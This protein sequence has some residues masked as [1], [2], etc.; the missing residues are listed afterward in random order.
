MLPRFYLLLL[1]ITVSLLPAGG[2]ISATG[3]ASVTGTSYVVENSGG[4]HDNIFIFSGLQGEI[5]ATLPGAAGN[6]DFQWSRYDHLIP[7]FGPPFQSDQGSISRVT[8]PQSG[9]YQVRVTGGN[10]ID[11]LL[12]AW[13]FVNTVETSASFRVAR[14]DCQVLDLAATVGIDTFFYFN[15]Y[16][17]ERLTL[18]PVIRWTANPAIQVPQGRLNPRIWNPPPVATEYTLTID[19]YTG[20]ASHTMKLDPLTTKAEFEISPV[21]GEA[22][23]EV[24]FNAGKSINAQE[25]QWIFNYSPGQGDPPAPDDFTS[26]PVYTYYIP[27]EYTIALRTINGLC[28][29]LF[30]GTVPVRVFPSELEV[31]NVFS[32]DGD[33]YND[34]YMVHGV[35]LREF[36]AVVYNRNGMKVYEWTDPKEGWDGQAGGKTA[37]PGVYFYTITGVGWD[38]KEYKFSGPLNLYRNR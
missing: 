11:T 34:V 22:P 30:V 6:L 10:G 2:Q 35:S 15:P 9:G 1:C 16:T 7:G 23:L 21:E 12:R 33:G 38:D 28:E 13:V 31:A 24:T 14:Y 18:E 8:A 27:G 32:P 5:T 17:H 26:E 19:Y 37:S 29:D 3:N 25:Y 20:H 4:I 36:H